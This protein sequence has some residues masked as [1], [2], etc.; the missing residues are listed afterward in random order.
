MNTATRRALRIRLSGLARESEDLRKTIAG[1]E[2]NIDSAKKQLEE[3]ETARREIKADVVAAGLTIQELEAEFP[4][5]HEGSTD[6]D[7]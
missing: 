7:A 2:E 6:P 3:V 5:S 4:R 1:Y